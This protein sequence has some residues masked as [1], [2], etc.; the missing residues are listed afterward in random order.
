MP[1]DWDNIFKYIGF[2]A[3]MKPFVGGGW[4]N[5]YK[6]NDATDFI[7]NI[8]GDRSVGDAAAGRNCV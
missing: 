1:L 5:V 7:I 6:C 3:Y 2:P 4:K 8:R